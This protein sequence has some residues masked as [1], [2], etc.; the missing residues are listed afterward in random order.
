M[1]SYRVEDGS[2]VTDSS[3]QMQIS[4]YTMIA[5]AQQ[6]T[7]PHRRDPVKLQIDGS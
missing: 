4:R 5:K 1:L 3:S 6:I 2:Q 7:D